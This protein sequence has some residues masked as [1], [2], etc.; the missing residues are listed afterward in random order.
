MTLLSPDLEEVM[1]IYR[2]EVTIWFGCFCNATCIEQLRITNAPKDKQIGMVQQV[3]KITPGVVLEVKDAKGVVV[4]R[5]CGPYTNLT[6]CGFWD[7]RFEI[8][9]SNWKNVGFIRQ[10]MSSVFSHTFNLSFPVALDPKI[11]AML[12]AVCFMMGFRNN[13][14]REEGYMAVDKADT[15][16]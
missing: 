2:K 15:P 14:I 16:V 7:S 4:L 10:E 8:F 9:D 1:N 13:D 12:L 11:K 5:I 6:C 3:K